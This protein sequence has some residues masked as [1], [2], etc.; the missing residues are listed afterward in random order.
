MGKET[1]HILQ[2]ILLV[3]TIGI[4]RDN[5]G[6]KCLTKSAVHQV[7]NRHVS[8]KGTG[9]LFM[10]TDQLQNVKCDTIH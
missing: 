3:Q 9:S 10:M 5:E 6:T 8:F 2:L 1:I 4:S 7:F